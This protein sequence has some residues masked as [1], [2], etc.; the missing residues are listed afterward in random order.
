[1]YLWSF[2]APVMT[3]RRSASQ[4]SP[5]QLV[6]LGSIADSLWRRRLES[7]VRS[8]GTI[9]WEPDFAALGERL[10]IDSRRVAVV[11]IDTADR[12]NASAA[13][14]AQTMAETHPG[15]GIVVYRRP[16]IG[17]ESEAMLL[18]AAGV[19]DM[20]VAGVTDEGFSARSILTAACRA[21][22][23]DVV[24]ARLRQILPKRLQPY[25]EAAV[26][27][28]AR[29]TI[30]LV[31]EHLNVHRQTPNVW[32]RKEQFI[33]AE[34]LLIWSRLL[35]TG[36]LLCLTSRTLESIGNE[37]DYA[38]PTALRNQLKSYTGLT[39]TEIRSRGFESLVGHFE[40]RIAQHRAGLG[41]ARLHV[42][43][44]AR[45]TLDT[46]IVQIKR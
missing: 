12:N 10:M 36:A 31:A 33:R 22:A 7:A 25:A 23:A 38:S 9:E 11:V 3:W 28:P 34:E 4:R 18:G 26:R 15:V 6:V 37:L 45:P 30:S 16:I 43:A 39:A 29:N 41:G 21:G 20:I 17:S 1:M 19:H 46:R 35:L 14:F 8:H 40:G 2:V 32:C 5:E 24:V 27:N 44:E 42:A 13:A